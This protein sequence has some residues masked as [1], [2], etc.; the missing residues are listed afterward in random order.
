MIGSL[1]HAGYWEAK[2]CFVLQLQ[3]VDGS[4]GLPALGEVERDFEFCFKDHYPGLQFRAESS[5]SVVCQGSLSPPLSPS[6]PLSLSPPLS[7][8][9]GYMRSVR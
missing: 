5:E 4:G 1:A 8:I 6:L 9:G 7:L 2:F 3:R